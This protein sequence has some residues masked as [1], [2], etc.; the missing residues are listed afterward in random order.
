MMSQR[1]VV[2]GMSH[3]ASR[4]ARFLIAIVLVLVLGTAW[5]TKGFQDWPTSFEKINVFW[6]AYHQKQKQ[7]DQGASDARTYR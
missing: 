2:K 5:F 6:W 7:K 3:A 4:G 1:D